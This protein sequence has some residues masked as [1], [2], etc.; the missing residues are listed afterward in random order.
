MTGTKQTQTETQP[1]KAILFGKL[2]EVTGEIRNI[3]KNGFNS[4][5]NYAF[6]TDA[7]VSAALSAE[8]S[9]RGVQTFVSGEITDVRERTKDNGKTTLLTDV[10]VTVTFACGETGAEFTVTMPGTGD[11]SLDKGTYKALTGAV[12]YALLK[13][14]LVATGDDPENSADGSTGSSGGATAKAP[15]APRTASASGGRWTWPFNTEEKGLTVDELKTKTIQW[16]LENRFDPDDEKYGAK[17]LKIRQALEA[18]LA[19]RGE[20]VAA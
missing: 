18:E 13:T 12:K 6:A 14:F 1:S 9:K 4:H 8:L 3:P 7:D 19:K 2:A 10:L 5:F 17:N 16:G 11:D 20:S 15:T